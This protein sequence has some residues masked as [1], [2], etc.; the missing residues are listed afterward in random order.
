MLDGWRWCGGWIFG[1]LYMPVEGYTEPQRRRP[2]MS[3]F[4]TGY[5][6]EMSSMTKNER[7]RKSDMHTEP[8]ALWQRQTNQ[9]TKRKR[10]V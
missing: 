10:C 9:P 4:V 5:G 1:S 8:F 6:F 3:C 7:Y 2:V